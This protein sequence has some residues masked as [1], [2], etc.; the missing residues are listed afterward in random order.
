MRCD[1]QREISTK[2][3]VEDLGMKCDRQQK[4]LIMANLKAENLGLKCN[5]QQKIL[6]ILITKW[7][8]Y[9]R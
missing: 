3:K 9:E 8:R 2:V 6:A 5:I 1:V 4:I 7:R